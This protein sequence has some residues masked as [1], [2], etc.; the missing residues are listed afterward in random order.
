MGARH[1]CGRFF[2]PGLDE[3]HWLLGAP[4]RANQAID[5]VPGIAIDPP[6]SPLG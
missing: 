4:E 1:E 5:A 3:R 6:D 2:V